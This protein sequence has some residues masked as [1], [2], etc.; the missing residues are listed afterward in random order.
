[1]MSV[2][3]IALDLDGTLLNNEKS[4][5]RGNREAILYGR[6]VVVHI[7]GTLSILDSDS[8]FILGSSPLG[9]L[10]IIISIT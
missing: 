10:T 5:S 8:S 3:L 9:K 7:P 6:D 4:V 2:K 1:M